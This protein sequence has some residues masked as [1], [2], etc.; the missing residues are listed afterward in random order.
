MPSGW[1]SSI[2]TALEKLPN[3]TASISAGSASVSGTQENCCNGQSPIANGKKS[4]SGGTTITGSVGGNLWG[5]TYEDTKTGHIPLVGDTL[6]E[7]EVVF[8]IP[9]TIPINASANIGYVYDQCEGKDWVYGDVT[10]NL[11]PQVAVTINASACLSVDGHE[12]DPAEFNITPA[13]LDLS[14]TGT[15]GYNSSD[16]ACGAYGTTAV[17][18]IIYTASIQI[19]GFSWS[20]EFIIY[21]G[22]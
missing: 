8:G 2:N 15:L 3:L 12:F 16:S 6:F 18:S 10:V 7:V 17:E 19:P 21:G 20:R 14:C 13:Q 1:I 11:T 9:V 22:E 4:A 5:Y